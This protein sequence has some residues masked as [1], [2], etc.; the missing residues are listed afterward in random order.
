MTQDAETT[1][2]PGSWNMSQVKT[3]HT[4]LAGSACPPSLQTCVTFCS[5]LTQ[6][7]LGGFMTHSTPWVRCREDCN[8]AGV[9]LLRVARMQ[10]RNSYEPVTERALP[11]IKCQWS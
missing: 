4:C 3:P 1:G 10:F 7:G 8:L 11:S 9:G 5:N 2:T 6:C